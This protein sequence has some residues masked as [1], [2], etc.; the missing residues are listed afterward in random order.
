MIHW[1]VVVLLILCFVLCSASSTLNG[2]L[3]NDSFI[4]KGVHLSERRHWRW[5]QSYSFNPNTGKFSTGGEFFNFAKVEKGNQ[6]VIVD[7]AGTFGGCLRRFTFYLHVRGYDGISAEVTKHAPDWRLQS[8]AYRRDLDNYY[9]TVVLDGQVV[10]NRSLNDWH[11]GN[12]VDRYFHNGMCYKESLTLSLHHNVTEA[13]PLGPWRGLECVHTMTK[14]P[15]HQKAYFTA[16]II[17]S[18]SNVTNPFV[19]SGGGSGGEREQLACVGESLAIDLKEG[20]NNVLFEANREPDHDYHY[21]IVNLR[22]VLSEQRAPDLSITITFDEATTPQVADIPL[23]VF[24]GVHHKYGHRAGDL[25]GWYAFRNK[26]KARNGM[27]Y[28]YIP[29]PF[30]Q[31]A[32]ISIFARRGASIEAYWKLCKEP[33][34]TFSDTTDHTRLHHFHATLS[35]S[36][37]ESFC[38]GWDSHHNVVDVDHGSGRLIGV[39]LNFDVARGTQEGDHIIAVD[40]TSMPQLTNSGMEDL[41]GLYYQFYTGSGEKLYAN[42]GYLSNGFS[43][44]NT[45]FRGHAYKFFDEDQISFRDGIHYWIRG[46][47]G[48]PIHSCTTYFKHY[49]SLALYYYE[50]LGRLTKLDTLHIA[51]NSA[52]TTYSLKGTYHENPDRT[53]RSMLL[54]EFVETSC[55]EISTKS[56]VAFLRGLPIAEQY[57]QEHKFML[58]RYFDRSAYQ[59]LQ[60][61]DLYVN[62]LRLRRWTGWAYVNSYERLGMDDHILGLAEILLSSTDSHSTKFNFCVPRGY[63]WTVDKYELFYVH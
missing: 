26:D 63:T 46:A 58:R 23:D 42:A 32:R 60:A 47:E 16:D 55:H 7:R 9:V 40:R 19:D 1:L 10:V 27:C 17:E 12:R 34:V 38:T 4:H 11:E 21:E 22:L 6:L 49:H 39:F 18:I 30:N 54:H 31:Q 48:G 35:T 36:T 43:S 44:T 62:D 52:S 13:Y 24:C 50:P 28:S 61:V 3:H 51:N 14:C 33:R 25:H 2:L 20:A 5:F 15:H 57:N 53:E 59:R 45:S 29:M 37:S 56:I 41:F 8:N